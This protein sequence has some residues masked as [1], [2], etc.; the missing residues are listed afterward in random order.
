MLRDGLR[1][2]APTPMP[3]PVRT[4]KSAWVDAAADALARGGPAAV[5]V[6]VLA[7]QLGVTRGGFYWHFDDRGALLAAVLDRW[8]QVSVDTVMADVD[9]EAHADDPRLRVRR[10]AGLAAERQSL[11][12][13]DL[14]VRDW[15]RRDPAVA[16]RLR[17]VDDRRMAY[18]R[19]LFTGFVD[20]PED[21]EARCL[22][23]FSLWVADRFVAA[24]HDGRTRAAVVRAVLER[25]L[26]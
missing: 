18:L 4:P 10:L 25:L 23:I 15:A 21:V 12:D 8:E 11:L 14:A 9:D 5:R 24:G 19:E 7:K 16:A 1:Q 26:A 2:G 17:R 20:D 22:V 13:L 3:A 6:D